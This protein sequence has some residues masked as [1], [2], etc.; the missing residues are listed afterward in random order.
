V[1]GLGSERGAGPKLERVKRDDLVIPEPIQRDL[2]GIILVLEG[3]A[4]TRF[5]GLEVPTGLL[6]VGPPGTGET[7]IASLFA[8]QTK[9]SFYP[10]TAAS[11]LGGGVG[12]SVKRVGA[13][14]AR[15]KEHSPLPR[16]A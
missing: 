2:Q 1:P 11:V 8:S 9:R 6:L 16:T 5:L 13:V 15:A 12:D 3:P 7:L 10:S 4:R 14:F